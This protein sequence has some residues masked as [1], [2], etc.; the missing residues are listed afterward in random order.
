[1]IRH[2][3]R[4]PALVVTAA[5]VL[6]ACS[7]GAS[8]SASSAPSQ[9]PSSTPA[10][11]AT[12][13]PTPVPV[14]EEALQ[15]DF[16]LSG[17]Y[18]PILWGKDKGYF[19]EVGIDLDVVPGRGTD[20]ALAEINGG[21]VNFAIVDMT[22]YIVQRAAAETETTAIYVYNNIATTGIASLEPLDG[23]EDMVGKTFGTVA[24]SSGRLNVPL[25]LRQNGVDW[26]PET[27]IQLMDFSVLYPTLFSGAIDTAEVGIVG[28]WE[29]A[30]L[31]GQEQ[32]VTLYLSL[33]SD[34][35]FKDYS[36]LVIVRD[37]LIESDPDRVRAFVEALYKSEHDALENATGDDMFNLLK[38]VD[39]QADEAIVKAVWDSFQK[40]VKD[41]GPLD[42]EVVQYKLDYLRDNQD[43]ETDLTPEDLFTNEF[44]PS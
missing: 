19:E 38:A 18:T 42:E 25:T 31:R 24:Q 9:A 40:Y 16:V 13:E 36:K 10:P 12:P 17:A 8:P 37:E 3:F 5:L 44:I 1:M 2:A 7:G 27:Q 21:R 34:W 41:P 43:L 20:L 35:G 30:Y 28:S 14:T 23:P 32:G 33:L 15:L 22:N 26:D 11:T 29:G 6:S 39:P 4:A